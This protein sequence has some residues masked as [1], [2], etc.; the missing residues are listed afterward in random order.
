MDEG[1][2]IQATPPPGQV[3]HSQTRLTQYFA[4]QEGTQLGSPTQPVTPPTDF[5]MLEA[6]MMQSMRRMLQETFSQF[7]EKFAPLEKQVLDL[8]AG[9]QFQRDLFEANQG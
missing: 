4:A 3:D 1:M 9:L 7:Q 8:S 5:D 2:E 6:R